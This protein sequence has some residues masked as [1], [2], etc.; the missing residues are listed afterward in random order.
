M[1]FGAPSCSRSRARRGATSSP[2]RT[3]DL[4]AVRARRL[5]VLADLVADHLDV[6][7]LRRLIEDGA[8]PGL[9]VVP[10]AGP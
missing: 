1:R 5:D 10:P 6:D 3:P 2:P 8:P 9:P 4:A 7:R